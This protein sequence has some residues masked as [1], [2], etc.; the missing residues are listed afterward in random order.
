MFFVNPYSA[1]EGMSKKNSNQKIIKK[2]QRISNPYLYKRRFTFIPEFLDPFSVHPENLQPFFP[3]KKNASFWGLGVFFRFLAVF[4]VLGNFFSASFALPFFLKAIS[5]SLNIWLNFSVFSIILWLKFTGKDYLRKFFF[6]LSTN[7]IF[8]NLINFGEFLLLLSGNFYNSVFFSLLGKHFL[9]FNIWIPLF[10]HLQVSNKLLDEAIFIRHQKFFFLVVV[11]FEICYKLVLLA[12]LNDT[13]FD[14]LTFPLVVKKWILFFQPWNFNFFIENYFKFQAI[15]HG[16]FVFS[17]L[18]CLYYFAFYLLKE[19]EKKNY[20]TNESFNNTSSKN[21][22]VK[23]S[24]LPN[25]VFLKTNEKSK[26]FIGTLIQREVTTK[27]PGFEKKANS[28]A[29]KKKGI[30]VPFNRMIWNNE[31]PFSKQGLWYE[32]KRKN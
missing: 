29:I 17:S 11:V 1:L 30:N 24:L 3:P 25:P 32:V 26:N 8:F 27:D 16:I 20:Q 5:I 22:K 18:A 12:T 19:I 28:W 7:L 15:G 21:F 10:Q 31:L 6:Q 23:G 14:F 9:C 13:L 2:R 4:F